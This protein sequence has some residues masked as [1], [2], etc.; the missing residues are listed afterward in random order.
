MFGLQNFFSN[1]QFQYS[2]LAILAAVLIGLYFLIGYFRRPSAG[3]LPSQGGV[4]QMMMGPDPRYQGP[5]GQNGSPYAYGD[6]QMGG[7]QASQQQGSGAQSPH[8]QTGG[9]N[10]TLVLYYAPWCTYCKKLMPV[11]DSLSEKYGEKMQKVDCEKNSDESVK[12]E[13]EVFPTMILFNDGKKEK[14]IQGV[15]DAESIERLVA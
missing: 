10:K 2:H 15:S 13:I 3:P 14:V 8:Q 9:N 12:Q 11:W 5:A 4:P 6:Y 7:Q 1:Y